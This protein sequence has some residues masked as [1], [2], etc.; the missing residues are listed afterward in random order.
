[1]K[2]LRDKRMAIL[3]GWSDLYRRLPYLRQLIRVC[4]ADAL[5]IVDAPATPRRMSLPANKMQLI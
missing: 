4:F 2:T 1:M 3:S 5:L